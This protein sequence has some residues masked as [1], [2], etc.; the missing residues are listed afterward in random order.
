VG[1]FYNSSE[2]SISLSAGEVALSLPLQDRCPTS[3]PSFNSSASLPLLSPSAS[4][5]QESQ[6]PAIQSLDSP[7]SFLMNEASESAFLSSRI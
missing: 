6:A 5:S 1:G 4:T 7:V 3:T 2:I